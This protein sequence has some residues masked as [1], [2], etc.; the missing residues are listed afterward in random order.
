MTTLEVLQIV[1]YFG[2]L[3]PC[4]MLLGGY[5]ARVFSGERTLLS[6][7]LS[8]LEKGLYR[9]AGVDANEEQ[10]WRQ[11][12]L[13]LMVFN[14]LG[15]GVVFGLQV[16]QGALPLNPAGLSGV[17]PALAFNTATSFMTNTNWQAYA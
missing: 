8:P 11:Y 1:V 16:L 14:V 2:L 10:N 5:M 4:V 13:A 9:L 6:G 7:V 17:E 12:A 15:F 3:V